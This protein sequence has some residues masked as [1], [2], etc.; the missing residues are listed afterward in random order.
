[1]YRSIAAVLMSITLGTS[2]PAGA[3]TEEYFDSVKAPHDGQIRMAGP[4]HL[5]LVAKEQ[6]VL[7]YVTDHADRRISTQGGVGKVTF[8]T[9]KAEPKNSLKLEPTDENVLRAIGDFFVTPETVIV[10]FLKLPEYEAHSASFAPLKPKAK[11]AAKTEDEKDSMAH[12]EEH[13][14]H[15]H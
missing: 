7:L 12:N 6:E 10:V 14:H 11:S 15:H 4:F 1:M 13:H 8:Q 2:F 9:S 5:E 3:H